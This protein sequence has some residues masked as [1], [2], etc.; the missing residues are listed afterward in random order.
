[1]RISRFAGAAA[2]TGLCG[3]TTPS[4]AD[5]IDIFT[6]P[7]S[8]SGATANVLIVLDNTSNWSANNQQW[9]GGITQGQAEVNAL[10]QV[11]GNLPASINVGL[12]TLTT[13]SGNQGGMVVFGV[14][15]MTSANISSWQSWLTARY[16]NITDPTWKASSNATYGGV[17]FDVFKYF[18]GYTSPAHANDDVAG[19]PTDSTHFGLA[20]Y[21]S[22]PTAQVDATAYSANYANYVSPV[23]NPCAKNYVIFIGN[24]FP[25]QDDPTLLANVNGDATPV[26][27]NGMDGGN[28]VYLADEW[29]RYLFQTDVAAIS[30]QQNV[31]TYTLD[32]FGSKP[33]SNHPTQANYLSN[34]ARA[35]G[36]KYFTAQ[37]AADIL[38]ALEQVFAEIQSVNT[39]F[40]SAS[41]PISATNRTQQ[42]NQVFIGM[43]RPDASAAPRWMGNMKQYQLVNSGSSI[44]LGDASGA[45]AV[46]PLTGFLANCATSFWTTDSGSYWSNVPE[47]P[48]PAGACPASST[49]YNKFSDA[50]DGPIVEKGSVAEVVRKGNN[51]PTTNTTP[52]WAVNRKVYT[53]SG[54]TL[55][56]FNTTNTGLSSSVV[57]YTLGQDVNDENGNSNTTE[58]RPSIHGDVVHSRPLPVNYGS[59][60]GVTVYYGA[61]DGTLRA[62]DASNGAER[63]AFIAPEFFGKLQ[64]L[65]TNSPLI[66]YPGMLTSGI[67]PTP[68]SKDYFFDGPIGLYQNADS[69]KVWI[70]P[71]MRRGGRML[72]ALDVS[73]P[74]TST[75]T[76][77]P[78]QWTPAVKWKFGCPNLGDDTGCTANASGIGQTWSTP[79]PAFI[80][81]F[82]TSTPVIITGG[83]YDACEDANSSAPTCGSAKG[84]AVYILNADTGAVIASFATTRSVAA[85]VSLI[86]I[87][88]DGM[89]DYA[90]VADTGGNVYRIS[91]ID[92]VTNRTALASTAW[93]M[94]KVAYTNGG[95]RKFL[96]APALLQAGTKVYVA[97]GSGD[98]EHPLQSQYPTT[99]PVTNRFYVYLDDL[100]GTTS[101]NLDDTTTMLDN[102]SINACNAATALPNGS[103]KGW[104]LNL[105]EN[106]VGE[107]VVTS[108]VIAGGMITFSTNRPIPPS[109]NSCS[110]GL[111]EARGYWVSLLNGSGSIGVAGSCGGNRSA[112]FAGGGLPPSPVVG[113][114]A[115]NGKPVTVIIGAA[116]RAGG[117]SSPIGS[118]QV[119]PAINGKRKIVYWKSSGQN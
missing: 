112:I 73:P 31:V 45:L 84:R 85:D 94:T 53:S 116:Q 80:K 1:M 7:G 97:L 34:M 30:G 14:N 43:F 65:Q 96:F 3:M 24:G 21:S 105:N 93:T 67:T 42:A 60:N 88:N 114:V 23:T 29:A 18:G 59:T 10:S 99:A 118:Q 49:S 75:S 61:N 115:I 28:K 6:T 100:A 98:R 111:G 56:N 36:G 55:V 54:T 108:A 39:T 107:Q 44:D 90:Y 2:L 71:S 19:T 51:P 87:D 79:S 77:T 62:I 13:V 48:S 92:G 91:F 119:R 50:P 106:G 16:N 27:P 102:T 26:Q 33:S 58:T 113:T 109:A 117:A 110:S 20:R 40:A 95:G 81:G 78:P 9:P 52:T 22:I 89:V 46:N 47:N 15:S 37:S 76:S 70:Y 64:R 4:L 66:A 86:D 8:A 32:V 5:D 17:M 35:G 57:N 72:Y 74:A 101:T 82:S 104:F 38:S 83:G 68:T 11:I 12:M 25:N 103:T 63:W 69:S 41:L